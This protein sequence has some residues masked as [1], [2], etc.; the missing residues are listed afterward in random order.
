MNSD[1]AKGPP[2]RFYL[3][4]YT[5]E[6]HPYTRPLELHTEQDAVGAY[7][8]ASMHQACVEFFYVW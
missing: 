4:G 2:K 5:I 3:N 8:Q 1:C 7:I 6:F